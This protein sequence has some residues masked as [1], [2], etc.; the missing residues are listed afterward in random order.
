MRLM[1]FGCTLAAAI[2]TSLSAT[3]SDQL[4][5]SGTAST[6]APAQLG[7]SEVTLVDRGQ[8]LAIQC[9]CLDLPGTD[10]SVVMALDPVQGETPT[11]YQKVL[12]TDETVGGHAVHVR[13]PDIPDLVN[14]TVTLRIYVTDAHGTT[15]C[16]AGHLRIV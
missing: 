8:D 7:G 2:L 15:A 10:V 14:H 3:A 4:S 9:G 11:G 12:L 1:T 13:V 6:Y 16:N 5:T